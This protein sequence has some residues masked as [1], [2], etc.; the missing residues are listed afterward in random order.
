MPKEVAKQFKAK[1]ACNLFGFYLAT[2][3]FEK[4]EREEIFKMFAAH[5]EWLLAINEPTKTAWL[6]RMMIRIF[7][8]KGAANLVWLFGKNRD[9]HPLDRREA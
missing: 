7:G 6:K 5:K 9:M 2:P 3:G 4:S 8:V 1:L